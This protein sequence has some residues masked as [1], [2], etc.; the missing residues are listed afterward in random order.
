MLRFLLAFFI[1]KFSI[2][3]N[4]QI[5]ATFEVRLPED[6]KLDVPVFASLDDVT[7]ASDTA[8]SLIEVQNGK[9][10]AVPFQVTQGNQ[11]SIHWVAK[12]G[13]QKRTYQLVKSVPTKFNGVYA[14]DQD[15]ALTISSGEKNLL[16]YYYKVVEAPQGIDPNYRR[17]GFIHPLWSPHGQELTRIQPPDHYH[18]YGVWNPW[19]HVLF[20][21]DTVDFWNLAKKKGTV[22]FLSFSMINSGPV[23]AEFEALHEHVVFERDA[24]EKVALTETQ[25]VRVYKPSEDYYIVDISS[26]LNC[27]TSSDVR[28]LTYRYGGLGWRTTEFWNNKNSEVITSEGKDRK[29]ADG[30]KAKWCIVQGELPDDFGGAVI[31]SHPSNYNHPEPLRV[32]P[33]NQND[34]GD[35]FVNLSPT[36]DKD[37]LLEPGKSYVLRYRFVVFNGK[38]AVDKA[39]SAWQNFAM[40]PMVRISK[41]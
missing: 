14:V 11:R 30:S 6:Q 3:T 34:R 32:W 39:E 2:I 5:I 1:I 29:T 27:A 9:S 41:K 12:G 22:R 24:S 16:R 15:G 8:L 13:A 18:H 26:R 31:M 35:V 20:E 21:H 28:L 37:W 25:N 19:T 4:A 33:E 10:K 40:P 23:F 17:S 36:K 7:F 38:F